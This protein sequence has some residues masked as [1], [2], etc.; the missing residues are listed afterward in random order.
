MGVVAKNTTWSQGKLG[1]LSAKTCFLFLDAW[2]RRAVGLQAAES[3]GE[4]NLTF[5]P[6]ADTGLGYS[7]Q[8]G[9]LL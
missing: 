7:A 1:K 3:L 2:N 6:K 4:E 8:L 5:Y 9:M